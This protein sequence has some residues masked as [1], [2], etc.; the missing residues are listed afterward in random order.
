LET[1]FGNFT[2][3]LALREKTAGTH[4]NPEEFISPAEPLVSQTGS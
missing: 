4:N 3:H 2:V 1:Q